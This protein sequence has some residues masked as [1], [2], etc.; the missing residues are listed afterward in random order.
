[1]LWRVGE[2]AGTRTRRF[3]II[4]F[5]TERPADQA[6]NG[7]YDH[8]ESYREHTDIKRDPRTPD[9]PAQD[10]STEFVRPHPA[11]RTGPLEVDHRVNR[12]WIEGRDLLRKQRD[13]D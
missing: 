6:E 4:E 10:T 12:V 5:A 3:N 1:M 11:G 2:S 9:D 7:S 13:H 8:S